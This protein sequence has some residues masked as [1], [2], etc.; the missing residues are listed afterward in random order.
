MKRHLRNG[1]LALGDRLPPK[2]VSKLGNLVRNI[3]LRQWM[4]AHKL[5]LEHRVSRRLELFQLVGTEIGDQPALYLEFGVAT[6]EATR[7]WSQVLR[8][9]A[10]VLHGFDSF[11]GL[12]EAWGDKPKGCFSTAGALPE[13]ADARVQFFKGRFEQTLASYSPPERDTVV[14]N[15]D[16]DLYSSTI[17]VLR[18]LK[19]LV[20]PGTYLYFD[21]FSSYGDEERAF[22]EF[23]EENGLSFR[24]R[25]G[26]QALTYV[27]FQCI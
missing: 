7:M 13:I 5:F 19:H 10:S 11:D 12:P 27:L 4:S 2:L 25:A 20:K 26:T 17:F 21:E 24:L 1:L 9:P 14:F 22:R 6:G 15:M 3:E 18:T 23:V 8:H 16:A